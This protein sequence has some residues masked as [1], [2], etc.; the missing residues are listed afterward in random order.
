ML[1][2]KCR[3]PSVLSAD[4]G[5]ACQQAG[6][7][8][9]LRTQAAIA[10]NASLLHPLLLCRPCPL[11]VLTGVT[12]VGPGGTAYINDSMGL[13]AV[14]CA[15]DACPPGEPGCVSLHIYAPPIRRVKLYEPE[16]NRVTTRT[17]GFN[18]IRGIDEEHWQL[19][20]HLSASL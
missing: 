8:C 13:H 19:A 10:Q 20:S 17:P 9:H 2:P 11:L 15:D 1:E 14:R 5:V 18:T 12:P 16:D 3:P 6:S 4:C 7:W